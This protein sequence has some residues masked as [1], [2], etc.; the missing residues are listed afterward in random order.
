VAFVT[1]DI[2]D[3]TDASSGKYEHIG[4]VDVETYPPATVVDRLDA[5]S[6]DCLLVPQAIGSRS[7]TSVVETIREHD[8]TVPILF[9]VCDD[10]ERV[11]PAAYEAGATETFPRSVLE[12][13][14]EAILDRAETLVED[15]GPGVPDE[16]SEEREQYATL[17]EQSYDAVV[18]VQEE[19]YAF[20]NQQFCELTGRDRDEL[21]GSP[22]YEVFTPEYRNLVRERYQQRVAGEDPPQRYDVEIESADGDVRL[23]NLAV[24]KIQHRSEPA[25]LANFRDVTERRELEQTYQELFDGVSDGL[26]LHDPA[27]GEMCNVNE[28]FCELTGYER[29]ELIGETVDLVNPPGHSY[30]DA[31]AQIERAREE[32]SHIFE[33]RNQPKD[34]DPHPIEVHLRLVRIRGDEQ[35][36]ASVRDVTERK[37][38]EQRYEQIVNSVND[39][40]NVYDPDVG[41]LVEVNDALCELTGYD[42]ETILEEGIGYLSATGEGYSAER[43]ADVIAEVI[44]TGEPRNIEWRI[45]TA[46]GDHRT[47]DVQA[48]PAT[49]AGEQRVITISR[50]VTESRRTERRLEAI[51]D[52]IDEAIFIAKAGELDSADPAPD[53]LS[54]GYEA[55]WGQPLEDMHDRY[56]NGFFDTLHPDDADGYREF[57]DTLL[58]D[59]DSG[60]PEERYTREYRIERPDGTIR[61]VHSDFYPLEWENEPPRIVILSRDITERKRR[62]RRMASFEDATDELTTV[63]TPTEATQAA[64]E[65]AT[66]T[67]GLSP[68]GAFLYDDTDGGLQLSASADGSETVFA[69]S[70]T[71]LSDGPLWTAF[72]TGNVTTPEDTDREPSLGGITN[73][74]TLEDWRAIPLGNHGVLLI[75]T[76]AH[77]LDADTLKSAHVL[78]ATLEAALNYV[79]SEARLAAQQEAL[80]TQ[81]ERA[82]RLERV[83]ELTRRVES[84]ITEAST[85]R[86]I[87]ES[88]CDQL[89]DIGPYDLVWIG[90]VEA[91]AD[92]LTPRVVSGTASFEVEPVPLQN[93][94]TDPHPAATAWR[95]NDV[96]VVDSLVG[97]GP[98]GAWRQ[99]ALE[100]GYQAVVGVPLSHSGRLHGVLAVA[101]KRPNVFGRPEVEAFEQLGRSIGNA[102]TAVERRRAL[103]SDETIEVEFGARASRLRFARVAE[104]AD[105]QVRH[106]RTVPRDDGSVSV[107]Y[108]L[109][110]E[111]SSEECVEE[112]VDS[113]YP[114]RTTVELVT[115]EQS[116]A[117][118]DVRRDGWFGSLLADY[119]GVLRVANATPEETTVVVELP[120]GANVRSFVDQL[121]E[122]YPDLELLAQ[123][124]HQ[125]PSRTPQETTA[126]L[127]DRLTDRQLEIVE[128]ALDEGYFEWP[129]DH[130]AEEIAEGLDITQPTVSKHLRAAERKTFDLLLRE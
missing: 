2:A 90:V 86:G 36:L 16:L 121:T 104:E 101:S 64:I 108:E 115:A 114:E 57:I 84:A 60:D 69:S 61:W 85:H 6:I 41:D 52:R 17:V 20:V 82:D 109:L 65:A 118:V 51:L 112:L 35:V 72:A 117:V 70:Q 53:F 10:R 116:R 39:I 73:P 127:E 87:E 98:A 26:V 105:C 126:I 91:G 47:L 76:G 125:Q 96:T 48:T 92:R 23:L 8:A 93:V 79:E 110:G 120:A 7:G 18:V 28:R 15:H 113:V 124:Q 107:H 58:D 30:E 19:R 103:E 123:R 59:V 29:D 38:H 67:L 14:P 32:G 130:S 83:T 106:A 37:R 100:S 99:R 44:E 97:D 68:V 77:R 27:T 119:G 102:L 13:A 11:V 122:T 129:R 78:A 80:E 50:D 81:T 54:A 24:S 55:I 40:I 128:A 62:E 5:G 3:S 89:T 21:I 71:A 25:T 9:L 42:R 43:A 63:D 12:S 74:A 31:L 4:W 66:E 34:G 22:F 45:E 88:V 33:W 111:V 49:I 1:E 94:G 56:E 46:D 95:E 75:G